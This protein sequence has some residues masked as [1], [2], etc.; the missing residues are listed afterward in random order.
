MTISLGQNNYGKSRVRLLRVN[1]HE[2]N[3]EIKDLTLA[4]QFEGDF[5]SAH[6]AGDNSKILATDTSQQLS[7]NVGGKLRG[8]NRVERVKDWTIGLVATIQI[9]TRPP[10]HVSFNSQVVG[11]QDIGAEHGVRAASHRGE[12]DSIRCLT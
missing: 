5:E 3:H 7:C 9:L 6:T 4:I 2:H 8:P 1:R 12:E 10:G 11:Q